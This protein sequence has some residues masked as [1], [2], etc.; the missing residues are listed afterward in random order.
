MARMPADHE[1]LHNSLKIR[2]EC[3]PGR[4]SYKGFAHPQGKNLE[5][6]KSDASTNDFYHFV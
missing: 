5:L 2:Y 4:S 1:D 6:S 3:P